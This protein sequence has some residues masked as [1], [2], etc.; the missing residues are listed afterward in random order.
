MSFGKFE[1]TFKDACLVRLSR[2]G[3][4]TIKLRVP[5]LA[6]G[7]EYERDGRWWIAD[8]S[9][10]TTDDNGEYIPFDLEIDWG[11]TIIY[12]I[13]DIK[14]T[15]GVSIVYEVAKKLSAANIKIGGA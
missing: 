7:I 14:E 9:I 6:A 2:P 4:K 10:M 13:M 12:T 5:A 1:M 11:E 8:V 15:H 3:S